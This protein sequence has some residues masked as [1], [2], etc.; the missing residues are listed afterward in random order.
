M[1]IC[2]PPGFL[3]ST[4]LP[5]PSNSFF[6]HITSVRIGISK[7]TNNNKWEKKYVKKE[8]CILVSIY[9]FCKG[10][11]KQI[12]HITWCTQRT[13]CQHVQDTLVQQCLLQHCS[14]E[15]SCGISPSVQQS[16]RRTHEG[17]LISQEMNTWRVKPDSE[18][19]LLCFLSSA[20][21]ICYTDTC[22]HDMKH[23]VKVSKGTK[24]TKSKGRSKKRG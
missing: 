1:Y 21:P 10:I 23:K 13:L 19:P 3:R 22:S 16:E 18:M 7:K 20:I 11:K 6:F 9:R 8:A 14:C 12:Y 15:L 17:K 5:Y 4:S 2:P 24:G